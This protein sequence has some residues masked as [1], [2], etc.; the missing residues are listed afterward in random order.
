MVLSQEST[1]SFGAGVKSLRLRLA[2][3]K[4]TV[5]VGVGEVLG[6]AAE[7]VAGEVSGEV[8]GEVVGEVA[9]EVVRG[10][11]VG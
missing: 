3:S 7:G 5:V 8:V 10:V 1:R 4:S 9:G 11:V 2:R 6:E